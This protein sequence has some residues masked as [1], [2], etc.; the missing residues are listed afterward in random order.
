MAIPLKK[1][2][3]VVFVLLYSQDCGRVSEQELVEL[4]MK[5]LAVTKK[6]AYSA[7]EKVELV[8]EKKAEIDD[9]IA[10]TSRE[11]R[12]ERI[13]TVEKNVLRLGIYEMLFDDSIPPKVAIAEAIRLSRKFSTPESA[14]FVNALLDHIYQ[15][16]EGKVSDDLAIAKSAAVLAQNDV[17]VQAFLEAAE[18]GDVVRASSHEEIEE[19]NDSEE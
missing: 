5:E 1:F 14:T 3:E 8:L 18:R 16:K 17:V 19:E 15:T 2:R 7:L 9:L 13:Q 11:Y 10:N 12:F 6:T 4:V